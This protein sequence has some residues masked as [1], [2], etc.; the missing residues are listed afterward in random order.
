M[1]KT[2]IVLIGLLTTILLHA[3]SEIPKVGN[4]QHEKKYGMH[5]D[6][7]Y[8]KLLKDRDS[9]PV[10]VAVLDSGVDID[11]EDLKGKIWINTDEIPDNGID[12]DNNGYVDDVN[13][14]NFLGNADGENLN[15]VRLEVTRIY[16]KL[17]KKFE[18]KSLADI[19]E[20]EKADYQLYKEVRSE[21]LENRKSL[22]EQLK[23]LEEYTAT[24]KKANEDLKAYFEGSYTTQ[25]LGEAL[26]ID[27]VQ[28]AA[29]QIYSL[30]IYGMDF[31]SYME[32][33][34][35]IEDELNFNY[36]PDIDPRAEMIGD[37]VE[38]FSDRFYGNNDVMG[39]DA[40]HG[41]HC[42]GIIGAIRNNQKGGSGVAD[43]VLIMSVRTVPNGDEWD[44]DVANAVR[45]AVDNGAEII[46]MSFGKAYSPQQKGVME[47]FK[48]AEE[49]GVLL[50]HAAG[51]E[52]SNNDELGYNY[53]SPIYPP[54]M[55]SKFTNWIEVGASTRY[56]KA[57]IKKG[58]MLNE[59]L[60]ADFSNYGK[61]IVDL[62]APGHTI[63][64]S[65][66]GN[67]YDIY[68]GTSMAAPMVSGTAALLKSYF[69]ELSMLQIKEIILT[70]VQDA[71]KRKVPMP[72]DEE[73]TYVTFDQMCA[74]AGVVNVYNAVKKAI[75]ITN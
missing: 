16:A 32:Y 18:G 73:I 26:S 57:K 61:E 58:F 69:P 51:N 25:Q 70:T 21:V 50:V 2:S 66:P 3:Q 48:Y 62:F 13:G 29:L 27:A 64:S 8:K 31:D 35:S 49:K 40:S 74:T 11:H 39:P 53:P 15:D 28:E 60:A 20:S 67:E 10:V 45:Y 36:N 68:G 14:W 6:K 42:A 33:L 30:K 1:K 4:W 22:K 38:D 12:D 24:I 63:Y 52:A 54:A 37:D 43:N 5:T 44:K 41:T 34:K 7:A 75:E 71:S 47:A 59:G 65:V 56:K 55:S 72:G 17:T 23:D 46:S 9:K 19:D